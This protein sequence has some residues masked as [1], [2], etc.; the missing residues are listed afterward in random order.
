[1]RLRGIG[2]DTSSGV[3][4]STSFPNTENPIS[5]GG[6]WLPPPTGWTNVRSTPADAFGTQSAHSPPPFDDSVAIIDPAKILFP[7]NYYIE[8]VMKLVGSV[9]TRA[10]E[11]EHLAHS[12]FGA[13]TAKLIETD[14]KITGAFHLV[15]WRGALDSFI[16]ML[17]NVTQNVTIADGAVWRTTVQNGV[18]F[19]TCNGLDCITG[20]FDVSGWCTANGES[21]PSTGQ[22]GIGMWGVNGDPAADFGWKSVT[23]RAL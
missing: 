2:G 10:Q 8:S 18:W 13:N 3:S 19:V 11:V 23:M 6:I 22:P 15:L 12:T 7:Q 4:Y 14:I 20:G 21:Y 5:E 1:M 17:S 16:A 9:G